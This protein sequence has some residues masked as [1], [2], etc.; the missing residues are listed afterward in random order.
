MRNLPTC[1]TIVVAATSARDVVWQFRP[2]IEALRANGHRV[3]GL[4]P[5]LGTPDQLMLAALGVELVAP[6]EPR[7]LLARWTTDHSLAE[8]LADLKPHVVLSLASAF[9]CGVIVEAQRL[10]T[11]W[12]ILAI[13]AENLVGTAA[14]PEGRFTGTFAKVVEPRLSERV[15]HPAVNAAT[16]ILV[17]TDEDAR[18]LS[19]APGWPGK[20]LPI[21]STAL[22]GV[23]RSQQKVVVMP[24]SEGPTELVLLPDPDDEL[25]LRALLTAAQRARVREPNLTFSLVGTVVPRAT[26][27]ADCSARL[28][29]AEIDASL[30]RAHAVVVPLTRNALPPLAFEAMAMGRPLIVPATPL[31]RFLVDEPVNG[32]T[33]APTSR[34]Q[35][36]RGT[37]WITA[38]SDAMVRMHALR[39]LSGAMARASA[40]KALRAF[41]QAECLRAAAAVFPVGTFAV[42]PEKSAIA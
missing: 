15:W 25:S 21:V 24:A 3:I 34:D 40:L 38:W 1:L 7:G 42:P 13:S 22:P 18:Q 31:G 30:R 8:T 14:D 33:V 12:R 37:P 20:S 6:P 39:P 36:L 35:T 11:D 26:L 28:H 19:V 29:A 23:E 32:L 27:L 16:G 2:L 17:P 5:R 9:G 41:D 4:I 10:G